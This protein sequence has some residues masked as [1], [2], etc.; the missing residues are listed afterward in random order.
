MQQRAAS[1]KLCGILGGSPRIVQNGH[2]QLDA[3]QI[4]SVASLG[5]GKSILVVVVGQQQKYS[6]SSVGS[7]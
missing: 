6:M 5:K 4:G 2:E 1:E 3:T 7:P